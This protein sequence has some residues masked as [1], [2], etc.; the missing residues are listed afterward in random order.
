MLFRARDFRTAF[1]AAI[2]GGELH[3]LTF[4]KAAFNRCGANFCIP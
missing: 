3:G 4:P 2:H 1:R